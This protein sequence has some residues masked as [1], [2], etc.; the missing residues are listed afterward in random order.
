VVDLMLGTETHHDR[1]AISHLIGLG[2]EDMDEA[3]VPGR[4]YLRKRDG[5][6]FNI[7]L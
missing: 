6:A 4:I 1:E 3:G 5:H 2:Y 7:A